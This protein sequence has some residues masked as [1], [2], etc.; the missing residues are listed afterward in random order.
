MFT[1]LLTVLTGLPAVTPAQGDEKPAAGKALKIFAKGY[2]QH[3]AATP[4]N[5]QKGEQ[6]II[7]CPAHYS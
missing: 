1:M 6:T 4:E 7:R 5:R 2:W 3:G